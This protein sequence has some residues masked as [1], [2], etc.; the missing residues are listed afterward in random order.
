MILRELFKETLL[1]HADVASMALTDP[2][3]LETICRRL[4]C[5]C[6]EVTI[7]SCIHDGVDRHFG[8]PKFV[9]RYCME[10]YRILSH[11]QA[12]AE[13]DSG[14]L[15]QKL[16][17]KQ[18]NPYDVAHL[19][20]QDL[21]PEASAEARADIELRQTQKIIDKVSHLYRCRKCGGNETI[22]I[23]YQSRSADEDSTISIKC[24]NCEYVWRK[25]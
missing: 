3:F 7:E 1:Q 21:C 2:T 5:G 4:E 10:C 23:N 6:F 14:G 25:S 11:L 8:N 19:A 9:N 18:L 24:T 20:T 13:Y 16:L 22:P 17:T 15:V 12:K